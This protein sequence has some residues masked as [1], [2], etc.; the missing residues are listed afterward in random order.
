MGIFLGG[1][2]S[3]FQVVCLWV[4]SIRFVAAGNATSFTR[5]S[6]FRT[7]VVDN[8]INRVL[9]KKVNSRSD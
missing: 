9:I 8:L 2:V 6:G 5:R 3:D 4:V 1:L 7:A